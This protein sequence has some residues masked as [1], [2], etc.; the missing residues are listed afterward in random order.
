MKSCEIYG[1]A[2][3]ALALAVALPARAIAQE[4]S[5]QGGAANSAMNGTLQNTGVFEQPVATARLAALRGG[6]EVVHNEMTLAGTTTG[7]SAINVATGS[8]AISAGAFSSMSGLP[9]VIQNSG[10]NVLIQN[11]VILNL[12]IN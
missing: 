10:A 4:E 5:A 11:A 2:C 3:V 12:Q 7:N 9:V 8:N 6:T 1:L